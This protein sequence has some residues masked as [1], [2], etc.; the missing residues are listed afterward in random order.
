MNAITNITDT[1]T[2]NIAAWKLE[3]AIRLHRIELRKQQLQR[4]ADRSRLAA[5]KMG[6]LVSVAAAWPL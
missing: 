5:I 4:A 6:R 1:I 2:R 3:R